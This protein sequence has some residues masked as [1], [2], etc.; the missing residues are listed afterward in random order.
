MQE[1]K[2]TSSRVLQYRGG[3]SSGRPHLRWGFQAA[4]DIDDDDDCERYELFKLRLYKDLQEMT[5]NQMTLA[6]RID[7]R[8][9]KK[10]VTDYLRAMKASFDRHV[11]GHYPPS[12]VNGGLKVEYIVTVP[13]IW[14][15][16]DKNIT[17]NCAIEA[18]MGSEGTIQIISEPEAAGLYAL[19]IMI[20]SNLDLN[21]TFVICDAGGG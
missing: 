11:Q 13:A 17:R 20:D 12:F 7:K 1:K 4:A 19:K 5:P 16:N 14:T 9:C 6:P 3:V 10:L 8:E 18:G 21:D 2:L 15:P